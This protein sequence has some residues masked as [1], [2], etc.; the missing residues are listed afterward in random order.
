MFHTNSMN[1]LIPH[2]WLLE[3][4]QT[5]AKP[6][7]IQ[8]QLSLSGP[9]IERIYEIEGEPVYDIE[10]TT[11]RV[12]SMSVR[13]IAREAAVILTQAG[14]PSKLKP[15]G[16][17]PGFMVNPLFKR[18]K[19]L[20]LPNIVN[21]VTLCRRIMCV[22]LADV[23]HESS[24]I[25][26]Q[27]RLKQVGINVHDAIIDITNYITHDLGHPCHAFD[28]DKVMALGGMIKIKKA[29][30]EKQ[31]TLLDGTKI[32]T[33][34]GEVVFE[35]EHGEIID[36]PGIKGTANTGVTNATVNVLFWIES[37]EP[38]LIRFTSMTHAIRTV[39]AQLNEKN[40][41][42]EL[43]TA[44]LAK[45]IQLFS[46]L[47]AAKPIP[48]TFLDLYSEKRELPVIKVPLSRVQEYLGILVNPKTITD[49]LKSLGCTVDPQEDAIDVQPPSWRPDITIPEDVV[50]EI[51]RI[52]GY[53]KLPSVLMDGSI[54][55]NRPS[56]TNFG[57]EHQAKSLLAHLGGFEVY[58]YSM[59]SEKAAKLESDNLETTHLKL[60]NPLTEDMVYLRRTLWTSHVDILKLQSPPFVFEL[61]NTYVPNTS[62]G[63]LPKEELHLTLSSAK[64]ERHLK[65]VLSA[66]LASLYLP[67]ASYKV[68]GKSEAQIYASDILL[69]RLIFYHNLTFIDLD[70]KTLVMT[71]RKYPSVRPISKLSPIIEDM[72][73]SFNK[74]IYVEE[75]MSAIKTV[76][77][78]IDH[79][80]FKDVFKHNYSFTIY[81]Q[82]KEEMKTE[83]IAPLRKKIAEVLETYNGSI[84]GKL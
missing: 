34:G 23:S 41:D 64:E 25:W 67:P 66:I 12:D 53:H 62:S 77:P 75:I 9:S 3:H 59:I 48:E 31:L 49:I 79:I 32:T 80:E 45:G 65:G 29:A 13:G 21:D 7:D 57:L 24:P 60:K 11:N 76:S 38:S 56:D 42:P 82:P 28:Y 20:P 35:N 84:V 16:P 36:L 72:T 4:L 71:A 55:T 52:Y 46:E 44:T 39:A 73:F 47:A 19:Q 58:T 22:V 78:L 69:G 15:E 74:P 18:N 61:A 26:M 6:E 33:Q 63:T 70:W 50:E 51:A 10:V 30:K 43:A 17:L 14:F 81:Y 83:E 8:K 27:T 1:I 68:K 54:P 40:V 5:A 2:S 37:I